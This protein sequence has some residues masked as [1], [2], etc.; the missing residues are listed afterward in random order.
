[1]MQMRKSIE[2]EVASLELHGMES[3]VDIEA[4][5]QESMTKHEG[6]ISFIDDKLDNINDNFNQH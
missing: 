2:D 5:I 1:M 3:D 6:N 4:L